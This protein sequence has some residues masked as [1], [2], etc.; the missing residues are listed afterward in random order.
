MPKSLTTT[1]N[2][3][4]LLDDDLYDLAS[5][6]TWISYTKGQQS[7]KHPFTI[8]N[9]RRVSFSKLL[10]KTHYQ[11][12]A[13]H[14][15]GNT[16]DFRSENIQFYTRSELGHIVGSTN[17]KHSEHKGVA[18]YAKSNKWFVRIVKDSKIIEGG[19]FSSVEDA[20]IVADYLI[21]VHHGLD[22]ERNHP[23]LSFEQIKE[24]YDILNLDT[25]VRRSKTMQ[26]V[27][28]SKAKSSK[29]VGVY[30]SRG[31]WYA[32]IKFK[33]KKHY[34]GNFENEVDAGMAYDKKAVEFYGI[35]ATVNFP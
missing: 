11:R 31:K 28:T 8:I 33:K 25:K 13:Y 16:F 12:L 9:G 7:A 23:N 5:S 21:M 14:K 24:K 17:R 20:T 29:Y 30:L 26:G 19:Y 22:A 6:F 18:Y 32:T 15:N 10:L 27:S 35:T 4:I 1:D 34:L 3:T 2:Q